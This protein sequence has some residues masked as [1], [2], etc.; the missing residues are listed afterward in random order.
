DADNVQALRLL[1]RAHWWQR[2]MDK[3]RASLERLAEAAQ[4]AGRDV[5]ERYALTQ[6]TRLVPEQDHHAERLEQL[7]GAEETAAEEELPGFSGDS[8]S[9]GLA[10]TTD[11]FEF[12]SGTVSAPVGEVEFEFNS[13]A[14]ANEA[15][16]EPPAETSSTEGFTFESIVAE[17]LPSMSEQPVVED[18]PESRK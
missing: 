6:L 12:D 3:L 4:A 5:D 15:R 13:V 9:D 11:Q 7:G 16:T 14:N 1:V 10:S 2:D 8:P 18:D 17:E